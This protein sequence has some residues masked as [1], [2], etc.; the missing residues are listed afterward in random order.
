MRVALLV[1]SGRGGARGVGAYPA[2][3]KSVGRM[4]SGEEMSGGDEGVN[5]C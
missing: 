2:W 5:G 1:W 4:M 3:R